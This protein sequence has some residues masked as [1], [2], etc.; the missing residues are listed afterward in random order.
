[1]QCCGWKAH[2]KDQSKSL[3]GGYQRYWLYIT[4]THVAPDGYVHATDKLVLQNVAMT[5][6]GASGEAQA[7]IC[8]EA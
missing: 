3:R 7:D 4:A 1:M 8:I 2:V 6:S 5:K